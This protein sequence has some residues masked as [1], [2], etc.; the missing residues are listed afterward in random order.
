MVMIVSIGG[1]GGDP[2]PK[3]AVGL[4]CRMTATG[5]GFMVIDAAAT[6]WGDKPR[7]GTMLARADVLGSAVAQ[8]AFA[9]AD[10]ILDRDDRVRE[11]LR[12]SVSGPPGS[13][14]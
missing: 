12:S 3:M 11:F 10:L 14:E 9:I 5:P 6:P 2:A 4:D 13:D 1:W 8:D 7:L